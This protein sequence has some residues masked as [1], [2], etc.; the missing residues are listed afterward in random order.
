MTIFADYSLREAADR[1]VREHVGRLPVVER[2]APDHVTGIIT[3]SDLLA[4]HGRRLDET[5]RAR[6][7][8]R[9]RTALRR[10]LNAA[11]GAGR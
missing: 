5:H 2:G 10:Y 11:Q 6:R 4:A 3:R 8:I 1:M 7:T 9:L